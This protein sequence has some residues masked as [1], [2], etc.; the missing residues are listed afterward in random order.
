MLQNNLTVRKI[1]NYSIYFPIFPISLRRFAITA[2]SINYFYQYN[3]KL[4]FSYY[5]G[6]GG[7]FE[8]LVTHNIPI[9]IK[10][11][12]FV[13]ELGNNELLIA[14]GKVYKF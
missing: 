2:S 12:Y 13:D 4:N 1:I 5:F 3:K 8:L 11:K 14:L 7:N 10:Y 9:K 6:G